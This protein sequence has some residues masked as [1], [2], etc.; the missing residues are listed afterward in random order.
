MM[1]EVVVVVMIL[2]GVD[3]GYDDNI[4]KGWRMK[5]GDYDDDDE[6]GMTRIGQLLQS[7][8]KTLRLGKVLMLMTM[9]NTIN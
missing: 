9:G 1:M 8:I 2:Q 3:D 5:K 6:H 4:I 7:A